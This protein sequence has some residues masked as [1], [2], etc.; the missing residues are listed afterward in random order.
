M[1]CNA[2]KLY[3]FN[4]RCLTP[5]FST[6][7]TSSIS[8]IAPAFTTVLPL[9]EQQASYGLQC[10]SAR[11]SSQVVSDFQKYGHMQDFHHDSSCTPHLLTFSGS[12][13]PEVIGKE[14]VPIDATAYK[15]M[16]N[17]CRIPGR[18]SQDI[19]R[20]YDPSKNNHVVVM[21]NN[22]FFVLNMMGEDGRIR[23]RGKE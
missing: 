6:W 21:R 5:W 4:R 15:Y 14:K 13:P 23:P 17:G 10:S 9:D 11:W 20:M 16:F 7:V 19:F 1:L 2:K 12:L 22:K 8:R 3:L 18:Q